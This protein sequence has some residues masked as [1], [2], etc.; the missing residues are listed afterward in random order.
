MASK[1]RRE[2]GSDSRR[3]QEMFGEPSLSENETFTSI[4]SSALFELTMIVIIP[5]E[6]VVEKQPLKVGV[7]LLLPLCWTPLIE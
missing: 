2:T 1:E 6:E 5:I 3:V 7:V 4:H